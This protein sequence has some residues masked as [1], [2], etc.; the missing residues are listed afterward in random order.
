MKALKFVVGLFTNPK[1]EICWAIVFL[2]ALISHISKHTTRTADGWN[3]SLA[4]WDFAY[5]AV[6][7]FAFVLSARAAINYV[8][9][10]RVL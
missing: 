3:L 9:K 10:G 7:A 2:A 4:G 8:R 1:F 6:M 5:A